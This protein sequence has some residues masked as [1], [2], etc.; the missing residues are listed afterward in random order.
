M[1]NN[2]QVNN[3]EGFKKLRYWL[4]ILIAA[5]SFQN[6][7]SEPQ[8]SDISSEKYS[9]Q[10]SVF[11]KSSS[12]IENGNQIEDEINNSRQNAITRAVQRAKNA[13][14]GIN[15]VE[16]REVVY[17]SPFESFYDDP[18]FRRYFGER[19]ARRTRQYEVQGLGSGFIIS[20]DGYIIT[21]HHVAGNASKVI[22][23]TT[24]GKKHDA[25]IIGADKTSDV[26]LLKIDA[27]NL[28][29]LKICDSDDLYIGEWVIAFG[30]PFGLFDMNA[31]PTVTVG[32]VSNT[33]INIYHQDGRVYKGMIQTD[34]AISSGNSGG[35]LVN[36]NGEVIGMNTVIFSTAQTSQGAGS[37]GIGFSIPINRVRNIVE[38]IKKY[39][40]INRNFFTGLDVREIDEQ[41]VRYLKLSVSEGVYI[42]GI[43]RRSPAEDAGLEPGDV[44]Y[45]INGKRINRSDDYL[46][47]INDAIAGDTVEF[48]VMRQGEK[49]KR[50][51]LLRQRERR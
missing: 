38:L 51:M 37:I 5:L 29:F 47:E 3:M 50:K 11:T 13:V 35:P 31:K 4:I 25:R 1:S 23:T 36:S 15:V 10:E 22:V 17:R 39:G 30:N 18:F 49:L 41:V 19:S 14:V 21:N 27:D 8:K 12:T 24:D 46:I 45:E 33:N 16:V 28:P 44:I 6:C 26:C 40:K 7:N 43:E 2:L 9:E 48:T 20:S 32:V 42:F 34:A